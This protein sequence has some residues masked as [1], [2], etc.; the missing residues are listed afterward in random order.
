M[1]LQSADI[2]LTCSPQG[3]W[4]D[5]GVLPSGFERDII[6]APGQQIRYPLTVTVEDESGVPNYAIL[7]GAPEAAP[8]GQVNYYGLTPA[9]QWNC[10]TG[11]LIP[12]ATVDV[13]AKPMVWVGVD[14]S[15]RRRRPR[16]RP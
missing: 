6:V 3:E 4:Y 5:L 7:T 16:A 15:F 9:Q 13:Y 8:V 1:D 2:N 12:N 11:N 10:Q 14:V